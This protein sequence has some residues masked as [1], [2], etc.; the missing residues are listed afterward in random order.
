MEFFQNQPYE[1]DFYQ[2]NGTV[3]IE[4]SYSNSGELIKGL[5]QEKNEQTFQ[6]GH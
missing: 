5:I 2:A 3:E 6:I 4:F 1:K